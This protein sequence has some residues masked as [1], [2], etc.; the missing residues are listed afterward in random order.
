M[1]LGM[2]LDA[3]DLQVLVLEP[4]DGSVVCIDKR[5]LAAFRQ[6]FCFHG[7]AVVLGGD[8]DPAIDVLDRLVCPRCPN[9]SL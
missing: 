1:G 7:K 8:E 5:D 6:R 3:V 4:F 2:E 9:L